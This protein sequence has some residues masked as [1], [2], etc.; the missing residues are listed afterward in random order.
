MEYGMPRRVLAVS[1]VA[2]LLA[3]LMLAALTLS[4]GAASRAVSAGPEADLLAET[5]AASDSSVEWTVGELAFESR[6]PDGFV[7]TAEISSS[8]GPIVRGRV[9]WSLAPGMQRSAPFEI[10]ADS[11]QLV[12]EWQPSPGESTP[13]WLGLTY[14]WSVGDAAGNSF[15]TEP[16]YAEYAD[17][18]RKWLRSESEDIIVFSQGLPA[19]VNDLT[20]EAMAAQRE[21]YRAAWGDLLPYRP[22]AILFGDLDTWRE[23]QVGQMSANIAGLTRSEWG[24]TVQRVTGEGVRDIAYGTVLHEIAHL[25]QNAFTFMPAGNWFIEGNATF[26]ER[27]QYYDYEAAVRT[28]AAAGQLPALLEGTGPGVSG[29]DARRGYDIGYTFWVWLADNYGLEGHRQLITL[30]KDG[31]G[32]NDAIEQVTG[33]SVAEVER[34]WRVWLGASPTAPTLVPTPAFFFLPSP[35]P[36]VVGK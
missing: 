13:P 2:G 27:Q 20:L 3:V 9:I 19:E 28:L 31:V 23:W 7:F 1:G 30:I 18:S 15:A 8:A 10:N 33:L 36:Y 17:T 22:R 14:T 26:F 5:P 16:R 34:R 11:G 29:R 32:R 4:P 25:Y 12:A 6:Y 21:T 24:G 35:T